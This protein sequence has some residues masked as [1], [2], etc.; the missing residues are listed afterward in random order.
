MR[1]T[2]PMPGNPWPHDMTITV[3]DRPQT[4]L[5][6][7]WI[8]EAHGLRPV[9]ETLPTN[10]ADSP[11][12]AANPVDSETH[13]RWSNAWARIWSEVLAHSAAELDPTAFDAAFDSATSL[14]ERA[15]LLRQMAG[16]TWDDEFGRGVFDDDAYRE[17]ERR[18]FDSHVS[19]RPGMLA[20]SPEHRDVEAL[21]AAWRRGLTKVVT[22]PCRDMHVRQ[23]GSRALL[24]TD[25]VRGDSVE[26]R[27]ALASFAVG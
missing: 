13:E 25:E 1:S 22:I 11:S 24:V 9:G 6:L 21:A 19:T 18:G 20:D 27:K 14:A 17:W 15:R 16:P 2:T 4:L 23:L 7:L 3:E 8:R 26:Y 12:P 10:L 5:E